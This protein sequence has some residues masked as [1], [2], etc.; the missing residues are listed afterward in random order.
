MLHVFISYAHTAADTWLAER[1][2]FWLDRQGIDVWRDKTDMRLGVRHKAVIDR[3]IARADAAIFIVSPA[4]D[5]RDWTQWELG[6]VA[7][8]DPRGERIARIPIYRVPIAQLP[9]G[10]QPEL[11]SYN[12]LAW[13]DG[14]HDDAA[15]FWQLLQ[16]L[17]GVDP[18]LEDTWAASGAPLVAELPARGT[19][20]MPSIPPK[21]KRPRWVK[22]SL[23]C[24]R[25]G[26]WLTVQQMYSASHHQIS[27]VAAPRHEAHESF[28]ERIEK[29]LIESAA[30]PIKRVF[31]PNRP[32]KQDDFLERLVV[33]L[34]PGGEG[35]IDE[36]PKLFGRLLAQSNAILLHDLIDSRLDDPK[37]VRYYTEWLPELLPKDADAHRL[38]CVQPVAW[39]PAG[40]AT[41]LGRRVSA[42]L[43]LHGL[44]DWLCARDERQAR[45]LVRNLSSDAVK[46]L[47]IDLSP[48]V[49]V[50]VLKFCEAKG[51]EGDAREELLGRTRRGD[52]IR[53]SED[54]LA[55]IDTYFDEHPA[56][57]A[58]EQR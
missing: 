40:A 17:R 20:A 7:T 35:S 24:G 14:S 57:A 5:E 26:E 45:L 49:E 3:E 51:I 34:A 55:A 25:G 18:G 54:V 44:S 22:P 21:P 38:K 12:G 31:W 28:V 6:R 30:P 4:W 42:A 39:S 9:E 52:S 27:I 10:P 11:A 37:L 50:D 29:K 33:A 43:K 23:E 47:P 19:A 8:H 46:S 58:G 15:C 32:V 1:L 48:I 36:L 41:R 2:E 16:S 56:I 53:T 13:Y